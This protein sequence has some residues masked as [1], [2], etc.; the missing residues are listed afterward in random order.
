MSWGSSASEE[1]GVVETADPELS[2][3]GEQADA[4]ESSLLGEA[5]AHKVPNLPE[6]RL[7]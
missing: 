2:A 7:P 3:S 5:E 6:G 1:Q 4:A